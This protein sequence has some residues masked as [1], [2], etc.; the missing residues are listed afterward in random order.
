M[1]KEIVCLL[2]SQNGGRFIKNQDARIAIKQLKNLDALLNSDWQVFDRSIPIHLQPKFGGQRG[3]ANSGR[4]AVDPPKATRLG[5]EQNVVERGVWPRQH[6]M[7]V[8]HADALGQRV[9]GGGPGALLAPHKN[10]ACI[11]SVK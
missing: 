5:P 1:A 11:P 4:S 8:H 2:W 6:E 10:P 7:L 9:G 3:Q